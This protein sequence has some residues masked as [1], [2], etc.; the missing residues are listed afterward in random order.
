MDT[1]TTSTSLVMLNAYNV[2]QW[3]FTVENKAF[4]LNA[5]GILMGEEKLPS[6]KADEKVKSDYASRRSKLIG[7]IRST[8]NHSQVETILSGIPVTNV[9]AIWKKLLATYE[10][11]TSGSRI[12]VLQ[13]LMSLRMKSPGMENETYSDYGLRC[14]ALAARLTSLLPQGAEYLME[15]TQT[16]TIASQTTTTGDTVTVTDV[17]RGAEELLTP[18]AFDE[19]YTAAHLARDLALSMI[20]I[21]LGKDD[22]ILR[23][24]LNHI[25]ADDDD[26]LVI[27]EHLRKADSLARNTQLAEGTSAALQAGAST[28]QKKKAK[29]KCKVHGWQ[30]THEDKDCR[31]QKSQQAKV[32]E[33]PAVAAAAEE[34]VMMANVAH[35]ASPLYRRARNTP[36]NTSWNPDSGATSHMTPNRKWIRNMVAVKVAVSLANNEI[37]W[38]TGKGQVRFTPRIHGRVG[39]TVIFNDVLYVPALRNNLFSILSVV[40]KSKMR[41]VIE[42]DSLDFFKN[43]ELLLTA[44]IN[45]NVGSLNGT[46]LENTETEAAYISKVDK[47]LL[48]QRLGHIGKDRLETLMRQDLATGVLVK[49][50]TELNDTCEHCIA[51][52]QHRDPFPKLSANRS[53]ELLGRIHSDLHG[54]LAVQTPAGYRYWITF[55]DDHS[56]YKEVTLLKHKSDAFQAFKDFVA[57]SERK[58]GTKVKELRDDKGGE[59]MGNDFTNWC[60]ELGI[61]RQHTVKATP[62]QNGVSERLNRT[63]AEGVIAML[64]QARLPMMFWGAA[65]L[66]YTDIL[67]ATPSSALSSTTSYEVWHK[68]KPDL[69]MHRVFGCRVYVHVMRKDRKN[70]QSHTEACIFLGFEPGYKGWKCYNATT[71]KVIVS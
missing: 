10:P 24:T 55:I 19:G 34:R 42:G 47:E 7:Y 38:A 28:Q 11:K 25:S 12:G 32:A 21:G 41:V 60:K 23:N 8:L 45:G 5:W 16:V 68:S 44:A 14:M 36:T 59:Y 20:P 49:E 69:S 58:L 3:K 26:P 22:T 46:T 52:K 27:L 17:S 56:R 50:G 51:G 70:L 33:A 63:L 13:E 64:N 9:A 18:S 67:N 61:A 62:Q 4:E 43:G 29:F 37:V 39:E 6:I 1:T 2:Q 30:N 31:V 71:K 53:T 57:G 15:T 65:V 48:H 35:I 54:P 66:Y 40:R